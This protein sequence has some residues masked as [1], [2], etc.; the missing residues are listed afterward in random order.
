MFAPGRFDPASEERHQIAASILAEVSYIAS[1]QR[2]RRV[3]GF[4]GVGGWMGGD[5]VKTGAV[6]ASS[7]ARAWVGVGVASL[8]KVAGLPGSRI[9]LRVSVASSASRLL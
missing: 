9:V 2:Q 3:L 8:L 7:S 1:Q 4:G 5:Y 6:S